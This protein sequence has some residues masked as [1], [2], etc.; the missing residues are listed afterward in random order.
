VTLLLWNRMIGYNPFRLPDKS[1]IRWVSLVR[2]GSK[3][4]LP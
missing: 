2:F 3:H 1:V 4:L